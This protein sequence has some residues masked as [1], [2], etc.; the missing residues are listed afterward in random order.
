MQSA[1]SLRAGTDVG[2][3]PERHVRLPES[4]ATADDNDDLDDHDDH[5]D[6]REWVF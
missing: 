4:P 1:T 2:L 3:P 6:A 5:H